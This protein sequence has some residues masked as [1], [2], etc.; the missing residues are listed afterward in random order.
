MIIFHFLKK[1]VGRIN[2]QSCSLSRNNTT[3][4]LLRHRY[5]ELRLCGNNLIAESLSLA[6]DVITGMVYCGKY[7]IG[8]VWNTLIY[9]KI[10]ELQPVER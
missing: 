3:F 9:R 5:M 7:G 8:P 2:I 4:W 6:C 1:R 10:S